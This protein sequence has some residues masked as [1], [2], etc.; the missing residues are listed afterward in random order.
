MAIVSYPTLHMGTVWCIA[1]RKRINS[2]NLSSK[3]ITFSIRAMNEWQLVPECLWRP[4]HLVSPTEVSECNYQFPVSNYE[5]GRSSDLLWLL[6]WTSLQ[7][8]SWFLRERKIYTFGPAASK[9]MCKSSP[10][11]QLYN[12]RAGSSNIQSKSKSSCKPWEGTREKNTSKHLT[13]LS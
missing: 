2:L 13:L 10:L 7:D 9:K 5:L 1:T 3:E 12:L 6:W 4:H 8:H 11:I